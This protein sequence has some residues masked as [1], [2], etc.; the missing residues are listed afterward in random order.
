MVLAVMSTVAWVVTIIDDQSRDVAR[1]A[2]WSCHHKK[3]PTLAVLVY[4]EHHRQTGW[5]FD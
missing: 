2:A 5:T 4:R 3:Q 1:E